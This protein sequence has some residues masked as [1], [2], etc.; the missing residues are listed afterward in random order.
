MVFIILI[1]VIILLV[2]QLHYARD[3]RNFRKMVESRKF[4]KRYDL[5]NEDA[6]REY[7]LTEASGFDI[8]VREYL[9]PSPKGL[10]H[11]IHGMA[12]H[13]GNYED[14]AKFLM[15]EG[16]LVVVHDHRGH[17]KSLSSTYPNGYMKSSDEIVSDSLLVN[18]YVRGKYKDLPVY[19]LGHSMGSMIARLMVASD[20]KSFDKVFLTGTVAYNK[21][22]PVGYFFFNILSFYLGEKTPTKLIGL[23]LGSNSD[24]LDFISYSKKN[25]EIKAKD[26][27]R[28]F[29]FTYRYTGVLIDLN[30]KMIQRK[31]YKAQNKNL[32]IY[33]LTG[34]DD[35]ITG[36]ARGL[37]ASLEFLKSLGYQKV[38]SKVYPNMR[39]EILNEDDNTT[40]YR[41]IIRL[42]KSDKTL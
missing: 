31:S 33:S 41:D 8:F 14:F 2:P 16:Y 20:D 27:L 7:Y 10:V 40:V 15:E 30:R 35:I 32:E 24:S 37:K 38:Y 36:G 42:M 13:G 19:V 4:F 34:V 28:I 21:L 29:S 17:G 26:R 25:R 22:A 11:I 9:P 23:A 3:N 18:E 6:Y 5:I 1:F 39:H 12:E